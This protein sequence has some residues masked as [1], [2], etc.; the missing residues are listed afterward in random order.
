LQRPLV[1]PAAR[2]EQRLVD[3]GG[4]MLIGPSGGA[5]FTAHEARRLLLG[6][7]DA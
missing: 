4:A 3:A 2:L 5:A 1:D 6:L 7:P